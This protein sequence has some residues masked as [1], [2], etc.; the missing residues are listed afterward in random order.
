[1]VEE[2]QV[3]D[4]IIEVDALDD[5]RATISVHKVDDFEGWLVLVKCTDS[6]IEWSE[7]RNKCYPLNGR[8][9]APPTGKWV[10]Y[11]YVGKDGSSLNLQP[12]TSPSGLSNDE[13][14]AIVV[15]ANLVYSEQ[16]IARLRAIKDMGVKH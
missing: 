2:I 14:A 13:I 7:L 15:V 3:G 16:W 11:E 8:E 4:L 12:D 10:V 6:Y 9:G 5:G 1:M